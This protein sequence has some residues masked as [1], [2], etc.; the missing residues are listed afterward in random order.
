MCRNM[1]EFIFHFIGLKRNILIHL[2]IILYETK[3]PIHVGEK[4]KKE[5]NLAETQLDRKSSKLFVK[6]I[7]F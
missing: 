4:N 5:Q 2:D 3:F 6:I 1:K 7:N